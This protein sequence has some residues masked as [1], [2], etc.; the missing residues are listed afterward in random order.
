MN[1]ELIVWEDHFGGNRSWTELEELRQD[2]EHQYLIRSVGYVLAENK[3]RVTLVQNIGSNDLANHTMTIIKK[4]I[5]S[6]KILKKGK[7]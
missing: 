1:I 4:N 5:V 3:C 7:L 6:R 2:N